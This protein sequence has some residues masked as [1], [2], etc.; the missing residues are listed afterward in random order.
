[1]MRVVVVTLSMI[2]TISDDGDFASNGDGDGRTPF[3][4][5][6]SSPSRSSQFQ[7]QETGLAPYSKRVLF[8]CERNLAESAM[9][10][11]TFTFLVFVFELFSVTRCS[12]GDFVTHLLG[13]G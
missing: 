2:V 13:D 10:E 9:A 12:R 7:R 5:E 4:F 3:Y 8:V 1:M 11:V 6:E